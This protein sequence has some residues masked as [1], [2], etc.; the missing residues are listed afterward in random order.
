MQHTFTVLGRPKP[1]ERPRTVRNGRTYT[2]KTT[3]EV[4]QMIASTYTGPMF[5]GPIE[6]EVI[7]SPAE[8]H[9]V[10]TSLPVDHRSK[11]GGDLDNYLKLVG[12]ALQGVAYTN[13]K[14]IHKITARKM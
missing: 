6:L 13:D 9:V 2:P 7:F 1:K 10:I 12:D 11:L 5:D 3:I 8:T 14:Q 4:Q